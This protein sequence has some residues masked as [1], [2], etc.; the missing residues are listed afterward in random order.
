[1]TSWVFFVGVCGDVVVVCLLCFFF[2][3]RTAYELRISDWSSD[4]C[5]SDLPGDDPDLDEAARELRAFRRDADVAGAG[6]V[7][8]EADRM[9]VDRGD[10]RHLAVHQRADDRLHAL[11]IIGAGGIGLVEH[12]DAGAVLHAFQVPTGAERL[13]AAGQDDRSEE[14][15]SE[16]QS[17]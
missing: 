11:A 13:A 10:H 8:A 12:A 14:H 16:L 9:A 1:M 17:L 3:Q 6:K 5:S 7:A 15:T 4:V 2:R